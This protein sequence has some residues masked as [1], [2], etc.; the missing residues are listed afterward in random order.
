[1]LLNAALVDLAMAN[2]SFRRDVPSRARTA[3][4]NATA[5]A[6]RRRTVESK[7]PFLGF[8]VH[9]SLTRQAAQR[10]SSNEFGPSVAP[11]PPNPLDYFFSDLLSASES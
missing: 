1:M 8:D 5:A 6:E 10:F 2:E 3:P 4:P 7:A 11:C 9:H